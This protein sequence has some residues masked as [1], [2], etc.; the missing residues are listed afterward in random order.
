[1]EEVNSA[2]KVFISRDRLCIL[3]FTSTKMSMMSLGTFIGHE[4]FFSETN[5]KLYYEDAV[6]GWD[7]KL[8]H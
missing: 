8:N 7:V 3:H 6:T 2:L 1:M 4:G 5:G